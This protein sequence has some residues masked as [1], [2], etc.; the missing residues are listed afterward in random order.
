MLVNLFNSYLYYPVKLSSNLRYYTD[1][2]FRKQYISVVR[3]IE[4][5]LSYNCYEVP[6]QLRR[7]IVLVEDR[8]YEKHFGVDFYSICRAIYRL[9]FYGKVEGASTLTQQLIRLITNERDISIRRKITEINLSVLINKKFSKDEIFKAYFHLYPICSRNKGI[10]NYC[11]EKEFNVN[12]LSLT[13]CFEI[14][15]RIRYPNIDNSH[16]RYLK[17]YRVIEQMY[18]QNNM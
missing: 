14:A 5:T 17:R 7:L 6:L 4:M 1:D 2:K 18:R 9:T 11:I 16:K 3:E 8:R 13:Q 10:Q 12:S 15:T